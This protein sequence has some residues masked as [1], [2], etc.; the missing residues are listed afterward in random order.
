MKMGPAVPWHKISCP[1]R[2]LMAALLPAFLFLAL[3]LPGPAAAQALS[4]PAEGEP[5]AADGGNTYSL[6]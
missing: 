4:T 1:L 6:D 5:L 3:L 2:R